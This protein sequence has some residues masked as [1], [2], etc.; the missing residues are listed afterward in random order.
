MSSDEPRSDRWKE[1]EVALVLSTIAAFER[2][3]VEELARPS[4]DSVNQKKT[5]YQ[6]SVEKAVGRDP[7]TAAPLKL[8]AHREIVTGD[9]ELR[10]Q[11]TRQLNEARTPRRR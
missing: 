5:W 9:D 1:R 2:G 10:R 6:R 4:R 3:K 8:S 11:L 7:K